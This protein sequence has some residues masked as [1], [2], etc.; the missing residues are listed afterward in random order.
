MP[1]PTLPSEDEGRLLYLAEQLASLHASVDMAWLAAR[2]EFLGEKALGAALTVLALVDEAGT[3]R[4]LPP[5]PQAPARARALRDELKVAAI[6]GDDA[7]AIL[8]LGEQESRPVVLAAR[9]VFGVAPGDGSGADVIVAPVV[10]NR[11]SIGVALFLVEPTAL[12]QQIAA[13]LCEHAGV[14]IYQ[15]RQREEARRL[16]SIDPILWIPDETFLIAQLKRELSRAR[17]YDRTLGVAALRFESERGVRRQFGDFFTDHLMRRIGSHML[18][19]VRDSDVLGALGGRY[20][21]IH[22][23]TSLSGTRLSGERLRD[24][25][26]QMVVQRFP[27][28]AE[29]RISL[30]VAAYPDSADNLEDLLLRL[31]D[32]AVAA[33]A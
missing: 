3:Y 22:N 27:E 16:H 8:T 19:Q 30:A 33:A 20:A 32:D 17:R 23:E 9:D 11:E 31:L 25:A 28:V 6:S 5:S 10:Y 1:V 12:N 14:A 4:P 2:L 26:V 24:A 18:A 13:T 21:V 15:L 7:S 29:P